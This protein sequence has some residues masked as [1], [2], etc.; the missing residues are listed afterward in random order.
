MDSGISIRRTIKR[1]FK[2]CTLN[3]NV[4]VT[5]DDFIHCFKESQPCAAGRQLLKSQME[6]LKDAE[7]KENPFS[8]NSVTNSNVE[9]A[10]NEILVLDKR[11]Q[12]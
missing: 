5:E 9:E 1:L 2:S 3:V 10:G 7:S 4:D 6:V 12:I 8:L 11:R